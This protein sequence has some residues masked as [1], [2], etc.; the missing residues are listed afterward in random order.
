VTARIAKLAAGEEL[1][2]AATF[3][4]CFSNVAPSEPTARAGAARAPALLE[5][6]IDGG[7]SRAEVTRLAAGLAG[8]YCEAAVIFLV[9]RGVVQGIAAEGCT[10]RPETAAFPRAM[11][12][13]FAAVAESGE[14]FRGAPP[15]RILERRVLRALGRE[16]VR[17]IAVLPVPV[18]GRMVALLYADNGRDLLGD[19]A[20]AALAAVAWRLSRAYE[21]LILA[22][23]GAA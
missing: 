6:E 12:S 20:L 5:A 9:H 3:A 8:A 19:A 23:K 10:G 16:D 17:E 22:R 14:G 18:R 11:P 4:A 2:D 1:I 7:T 13:V 15:D 21:R